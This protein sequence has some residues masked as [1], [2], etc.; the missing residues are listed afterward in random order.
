[1]FGLN[2][3]GEITVIDGWS[4]VTLTDTGGDGF[5]VSHVVPARLQSTAVRVCV[6]SL[7]AL[8][9]IVAAYGAVASNAAL[10]P[11]T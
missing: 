4:A 9:P 8:V 1:M 6:P 3:L 11:S 2:G 10:P 5:A 7:N